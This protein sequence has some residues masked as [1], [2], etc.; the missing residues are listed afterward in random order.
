LFTFISVF[1]NLTICQGDSQPE[2]RRP[3]R[4]LAARGSQRLRIP[5]LEYVFPQLGQKNLKSTLLRTML[6]QPRYRRL[7]EPFR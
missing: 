2:V 3:Q 1:F 5:P 7:D 4:R 6:H